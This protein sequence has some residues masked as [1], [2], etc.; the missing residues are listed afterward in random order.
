MNNINIH[1]TTKMQPEHII[2]TGKDEE[3]KFFV[4]CSN[5]G[6]C[7]L[8]NSDEEELK[9]TK[10]IFIL[11]GIPLFPAFKGTVSELLKLLE[12]EELAKCIEKCIETN[13]SG[14]NLIENGTG[15]NLDRTIR[16][17]LLDN[18]AFRNNNA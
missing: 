13:V 6:E 10:E 16:K 7:Y 14:G 18:C 11:F 8:F 15:N 17:V 1:F 4:R 2:D 3:C 12:N 5:S 9:T